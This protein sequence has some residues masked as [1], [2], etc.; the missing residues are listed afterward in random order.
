L[1]S[2]PRFAA[3]C[4]LGRGAKQVPNHISTFYHSH[5]RTRSVRAGIPTLSVNAIKLSP[6]TFFCRVGKVF[7][8]PTVSGLV[9]NKNTLPTLHKI[10]NLMA[11][12]LSVGT[13]KG[14]TQP[15]L[16]LTWQVLFLTCQV[17]FSAGAACR[18]KGQA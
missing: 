1:I 9:G 16:T 8:L 2:F 11:L 3:E 15:Y 12:T 6:K 14:T 5:C 13:R 7:F 17:L 10:L 18:S 4:L